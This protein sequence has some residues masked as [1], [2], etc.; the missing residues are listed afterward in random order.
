MAK[1]EWTPLTIAKL[2]PG[3]YIAC[4]PSL[5][6][7]GIVWFD[8]TPSEVTIRGAEKLATAP[9]DRKG[10]DDTFYR[11]RVMEA[12]LDALFD[13]WEV[14]SD[15]LAVHE[16]PPAGGGQFVRT[17]ASILT[18]FAF[19]TVADEYGLKIDATVTPQSV[20]KLICGNHLAPKAE[21]HTELKKLFPVIAHNEMIKNEA[22]RD[23]LGVG[24]YSAHRQFEKMDSRTT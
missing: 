19:S 11:A 9:T 18:G 12:L 1:K 15:T 22:L 2:W 4:D 3:R 14:D 5:A 21:W 13:Q 7:L 8:V 6:A 24:L 20:R 16:A 10:W 23:A 17:E